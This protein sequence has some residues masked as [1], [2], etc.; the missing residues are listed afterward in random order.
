MAD[1]YRSK[2][3][4]NTEEY[5]RGMAEAKSKTEQFQKAADNTGK[6][7]QNLENQ[8]RS[9]GRILE[10][11]AGSEKAARSMQNYRGQLM[12]VT[13]QIQDL[14]VTYRNMDSAMKASSIGQE[15]AAKIRE[16]TA[17]AAQ[18]KDAIQDV[19]QEITR[20]A[21]DTAIWDGM[22]QGIEGVSSVL[23]SFAAAGILGEKST[24]K[25]VKVIAKLKGVEAATNAVIR[26]GNM[27]QKNSAAVAAIRTVQL[28]L[29]TKA[30]GE[31]TIAQKLL[32]AAM[33]ANPVGILIGLLATVAAGIAIFTSRTKEATEAQEDENKALEKAKE[34]WE[35]FKKSIGSAVG[36]VT[37]KFKSLQH[38][39]SRLSSEMEKKRWIEEN[40]S[41]FDK[42]NL[43]ITDVNSA[44][45]VFIKQSEA[46]IAAL[47][48]RARANALQSIYEEK[49]KEQAEAALEAQKKLN[50]A[51][52]VNAG[53]RVSTDAWG[54][55]PDNWQKAGLKQNQDYTYEWGGGQ[56]GMGYMTLTEEGARKMNEFYRN[57]AQAAGDELINATTT[58]IAII[59]GM[60]DDAEREAL[61][62]E[63][64]VSKLIKPSGGSGS[65]SGS[66]GGNNKP[67]EIKIEAGSLAEAQKKVN[68][69]QAKLNAMSPDNEAFASTK[70]E[71]AAAQK[72]VERIKALLE[73]AKGV[74]IPEWDEGSLAEAQHFV[75]FFQK[76]LD[77]LDP[78]SDEFNETLE[79]LRLWQQRV[80]EIRKKMGEITEESESVLDA[81]KRIER[82]A[83][84]INLSLSIG[85]ID[86]KTAREA[87]R[88]LNEELQAL[89]LT[90]TVGLDID[91]PDK[92]ELEK[93]LS[94]TIDTINDYF[95]KTASAFTAPVHAVNNVVS[96]FENMNEKMSDPD[97][98]AWEQFFSVFQVGESIIQGVSTVM[99]VLATVTELL[100]ALKTKNAAA[101]AAETAATTAETAASG[102][103]TAAKITE[104]AATGALAGAEAGSSV[105]SVPY[106][107][108]IL[109]I[110]AIAAVMAAIIGIIASA[111]GFAEGGIVGGHSYTGDKILARVNSQELILTKE[112]QDAAWR[113]MNQ[114]NTVE[115]QPVAGSV[116]FKVHGTDLVGVLNNY[117]NKQSKI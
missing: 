8:S 54:N 115:R 92:K 101:S 70:A 66:G 81:Y 6:T 40:K 68:E 60:W 16:L 43:A 74:E 38:S 79:I 63:A 93:T 35:N 61:A 89:G 99:S 22:K 86:E 2:L 58:D 19:Q 17:Q 88:K 94:G 3:G 32:N 76:E 87:I 98:S 114:I 83:D 105:A 30:T 106:V 31:A 96:A 20:M 85:A 111:K 75:T 57:A 109:A 29:Q 42:L 48:A 27:L 62:A 64:A 72:E 45:E 23:Q 59:E 107:G 36:D 37:G 103:N 52:K 97:A 47:K 21:S 1:D 26:I 65:G 25:L 33:N 14:T 90:I 80:D 104:A 55:A 91:A 7:L 73:E 15:T 84:E 108:P 34:D 71:L 10:D 46:V 5:D 49:Y 77:N 56:S 100:T 69:L 112:Q 113:Q 117:S 50:D 13:K 39:Y 110:A 51:T 116:T 28:K 41:A 102:A 11:I 44:D 24:E 9:T 18:Y 4:L 67:D 53:L 95:S 78:A 12:K 82:E